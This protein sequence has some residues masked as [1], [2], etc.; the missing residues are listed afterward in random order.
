MIILL[1]SF[2]FLLILFFSSQTEIGDSV[3][4][5]TN[6]LLTRTLNGECNFMQRLYVLQD[7][8]RLNSKLYWNG[9]GM[10]PVKFEDRHLL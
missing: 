10:C 6:L 5:S 3:R 9:Q 7:S 8:S 2:S 1:M 4:K